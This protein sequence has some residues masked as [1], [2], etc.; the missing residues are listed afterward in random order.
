MFINMP[1]GHYE[2]DTYPSNKCITN[3]SLMIGL[4]FIYDESAI[5]K[6]VVIILVGNHTKRGNERNAFYCHND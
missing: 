5:K 1:H 4:T 2:K 3:R 6:Q